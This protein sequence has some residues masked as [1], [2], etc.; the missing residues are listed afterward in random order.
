MP[1]KKKRTTSH[2]DKSAGLGSGTVGGAMNYADNVVFG[3]EQ[4][5]GYAAEKANHLFDKLS[6]KNAVIVGEGNAK[7]GPDR[8]VDGTFIQTKYCRSGAKC[9]EECF[10]NGTFKYLDDTNLSM[11]IEVPSDMYED[12]VRAMERRIERGE[13]PGV[14]DPAQ[15]REII[16]KGH[17][18]YAQAKNI[19]KA[20]TIESLTYDSVNGIKL[21]S[22]AMGISAALSF[23]MSIWSGENVETA[24]KEACKASIQVGGVTWLGSVLSSQLGR[25]GLEQTLRG[26]TDLLVKQLGPKF[27]AWI[28]NGLRNGPAIH[29]A[30]A[31]KYLSKLL[32]GNVVTGVAT[33]AVLSSVDFVRM[34]RG[35]MSGTQVFKNFTI[36]A[37]SVGGGTAGW[38]I[39]TSI[40][41][42]IGSVIP[43]VGTSIGGIA[44]GILGA[45]G[46]GSAS[47][48]VTTAVLDSFIE[49][50]AWK[51]LGIIE[52]V[53]GDLGHK[54]VLNDSEAKSVIEKFKD[55]DVPNE[56]RDMYASDKRK[57][58]ARR[59]LG[60]IV[61]EIVEG[62]K[63]VVL[64]KSED[65][66]RG[67]ELVLV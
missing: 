63:S 39:G 33:T 58:Y 12:A 17:F 4:G 59:L 10:E 55:M 32:R 13:V 61:K 53:F 60:G 38:I 46:V 27:S 11:Q 20:G 19:A 64:P 36:T 21:A 62:R 45:I 49:D 48:K 24:L 35:R 1:D 8:L 65:M 34:F 31:S 5:H 40:G 52:E 30:A 28:A 16:R 44:G 15:A 22:Q 57:A 56:L 7:G 29:G 51:M 23:A 3:C 41:S 6:G 14:S 9:V 42:S 47:S 50:D 37:S 18:T 67:A 25:T 26:S 66:L 54:Y 2:V 43:V